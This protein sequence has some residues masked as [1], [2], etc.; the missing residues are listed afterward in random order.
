MRPQCRPAHWLSA[1]GQ[2]E[3]RK[4]EDPLSAGAAP[5]SMRHAPWLRAHTT[6]AGP[7]AQ[8]ECRSCN[9]KESV[10]NPP[11]PR[12]HLGMGVVRG[13][14][15]RRQPHQPVCRRPRG[16]QQQR[17]PCVHLGTGRKRRDRVASCLVGAWQS[18]KALARQCRPT[19]P[20]R[21]PTSPACQ[22]AVNRHPRHRPGNA[23]LSVPSVNR[24]G[25]GSMRRGEKQ[26][27][28]VLR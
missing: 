24:R 8:P 2:A 1:S 5:S 20:A 19:Q 26:R 3:S 22:P 18:L 10:E 21:P 27:R 6:P 13:G 12:P 14:V 28:R 17:Q 4:A 25:G 11:A 15:L 16:A 9:A 7:G 23:R